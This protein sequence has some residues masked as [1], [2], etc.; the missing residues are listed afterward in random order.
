MAVTGLLAE[1]P[2]FR[3]EFNTETTRLFKQS[4][5]AKVAGVHKDNKASMK[6][7]Y[8]AVRFGHWGLTHIYDEDEARFDRE[9]ENPSTHL[10]PESWVP[11]PTHLFKNISITL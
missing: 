3:A 6:T 11:Q 7:T 1:N 10:K 2:F 9:I 5:E 8:R 4:L